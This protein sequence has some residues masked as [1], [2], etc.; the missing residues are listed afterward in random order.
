MAFNDN[1]LLEL[2]KEYTF[3]VRVKDENQWFAGTL[4]LS[5]QQCTLHMMTERY[6]YRDFFNSELIIECSNTFQNKFFLFDCSII[7][8]ESH[9]IERTPDKTISSFEYKFKIGFIV[10][11]E[12]ILSNINDTIEGFSIV[13]EN[14]KKWVG[15]THN[16]HK[17]MEHFRK[18]KKYFNDINDVEFSIAI[19]NYGKMAIIYNPQM[20]LD[21]TSLTSGIKLSAETGIRFN[22]NIAMNKI[23]KE[24]DKFY[25]LMT[26]LIGSDF[27][28][29][30]IE[31][32]I[33][34][35][36]TSI[37]SF[38]LPTAHR[39][40]ESEYPLLPLGQNLTYNHIDLK[41]LP[42]DCFNNYY[43][44]SNADQLLFTRYLRYKRMKSD[45]EKFLGYFRL[46]EKLTYKKKTYVNEKPLE[47]LLKK[48]KSY[49]A[50][51]LDV[52]T[53]VIND[54]NNRILQANGSKYNT[55]KCISDFYDLVPIEIQ[56]QLSY[57]KADIQM[58]C[59]LR[60]D[61]THANEYTLDDALLHNYTKFI[62]AL[63]FLA[64]TQKIGIPFDVCIPIAR[65]LERV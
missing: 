38:Y 5:P 21:M 33:S 11:C 6:P 10:Y 53:K 40:S 2:D 39:V 42:L 54:L 56:E 60:N 52:K 41:E 27:K 45:E 63:L 47:N 29:S 44:L 48:T 57:K 61:I 36:S 20:H 25:T 28:I 16:Q 14:I 7:Q 50:K 22:N 3:K 30:T 59:K 49:L 13:S 31:L 32:G 9:V 55:A 46:L 26:L 18:D 64:L 51:K 17:L 58:I 4:F 19:N 37:V 43:Q 62:N 1:E 34:Q 24:I 65:G 15:I 12:N 8:Y 35:L 23:G